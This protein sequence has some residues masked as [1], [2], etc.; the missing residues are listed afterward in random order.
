MNKAERSA[1]AAEI[2]NNPVWEEMKQALP[3]TYYNAFKDAIGDISSRERISL[4]HD[5]F[6]DV[7]AYIEASF[8]MGAELELPE[9][10]KTG[11]SK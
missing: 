8:V 3:Q 2:L 6:N 5:I 1:H 4:A 10:L 11:D 9:E 7:A